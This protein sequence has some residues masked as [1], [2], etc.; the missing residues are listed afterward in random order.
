[1][2]VKL[3]FYEALQLRKGV[4]VLMMSFYWN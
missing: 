4:R 3:V 2:K 1:L